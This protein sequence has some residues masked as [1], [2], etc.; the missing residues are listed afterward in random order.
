MRCSSTAAVVAA[1]AA[2]I[3]HRMP[4]GK[5][6]ADSIQCFLSLDSDTINF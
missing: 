4:D 2:A 1:A 6:V 3:R 5:I